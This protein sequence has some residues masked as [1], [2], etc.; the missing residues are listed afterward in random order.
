[1]TDVFESIALRCTM[2][3][4]RAAYE[5]AGLGDEKA[6]DRAAVDAIRSVLNLQQRVRARIVI[7]EGE[8]DDAP[9]LYRGEVL[10]CGDIDVDIA[11]DPLE[12]TTACAK[13]MDGA[14]SVI[15]ISEKGGLLES[16]D[17][18]MEKIVYSSSLPSGALSIEKNSCTEN[19]KRLAAIKGCLPSELKVMVLDRGRHRG[20]IDELRALNVRVMLIENGDLVGA[21]RAALGEIDLYIG[22]GGAPEGVLAAAAI[23]CMSG[24]KN[25]QCRLQGKLL[26]MDE[27]VKKPSVLAMTA[28]TDCWGLSGFKNG[29]SQSVIFTPGCIKRVQSVC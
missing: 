25:F 7:G 29:K 24:N 3:G 5:S 10:G 1:M 22:T 8:R 13:F 4:A 14:V 28:I 16:P 12:C 11:V 18:Y 27:I 23:S 26:G 19:I 6:A 9:M 17:V 21:I 2:H 15:A 20:I